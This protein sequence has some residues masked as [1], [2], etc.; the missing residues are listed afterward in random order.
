ME[1]NFGVFSKTGDFKSSKYQS[2][3]SDGFAGFFSRVPRDERIQDLGIRIIDESKIE[4]NIQ[5]PFTLHRI[6][7]V[8][9]E[10]SHHV[11]DLYV[12]RDPAPVGKTGPDA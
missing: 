9:P 4:W 10:I 2:G 7:P 12:G 5:R 8:P 6:H 3:Q 1:P 11:L